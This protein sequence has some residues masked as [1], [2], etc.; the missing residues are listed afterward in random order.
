[1]S[2]RPLALGTSILAILLVVCGCRSATDEA[3]DP[4]IAGLAELAGAAGAIG[5]SL[6][7]TCAVRQASGDPTKPVPWKTGAVTNSS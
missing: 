3:P 4:P 6:D 2:S 7:A 5:S 1:M